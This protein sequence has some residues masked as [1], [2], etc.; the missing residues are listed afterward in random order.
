MHLGQIFYTEQ[1]QPTASQCMSNMPDHSSRQLQAAARVALLQRTCKPACARRF[2]IRGC[3]ASVP[4]AAARAQ[5]STGSCALR[6][7]WAS[8]TS[9]TSTVRT[10]QVLPHTFIAIPFCAAEMQTCNA[11]SMC[12]NIQT[13]LHQAVGFACTH[14]CN[15]S[16]DFTVTLMLKMITYM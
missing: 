15:H 7:A 3:G 16:I 14:F 9:S 1:R 4:D 5:P 12:S 6:H 11:A 10:N 2:S 13:T 8:R